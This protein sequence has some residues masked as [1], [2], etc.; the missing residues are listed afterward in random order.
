MFGMLRC[1][2]ITADGSHDQCINDLDLLARIRLI[3]PMSALAFSWHLA[4]YRPCTS[5][6]A[7]AVSHAYCS[8]SSPAALSPVSRFSA[9]QET[10]LTFSQAVTSY[11][12]KAKT[13]TL[14]Q[15]AVRYGRAVKTC[16]PQ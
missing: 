5:A 3:K 1:A 2:F 15:Y 14:T 4:S 7:C 16:T 10:T 6:R 8:D 11:R 9:A 12:E 13:N